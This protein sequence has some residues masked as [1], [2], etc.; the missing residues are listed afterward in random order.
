[1]QDVIG[2]EIE[3]TKI[4]LNAIAGDPEA[5]SELLG[6]IIDRVDST[7]GLNKIV[8]QGW[9]KTLEDVGSEVLTLLA[10]K[11]SNL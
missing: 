3:I 5:V 2:C 6:F 7:T 10:T 11:T 1:M 8:F 9:R 4:Q